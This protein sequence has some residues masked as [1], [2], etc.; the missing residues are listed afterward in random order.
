VQCTTNNFSLE[1]LSVS[2]YIKQIKTNRYSRGGVS[3]SA[4]YRKYTQCV[5]NGA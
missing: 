4:F 3:Q 5:E 1:L 2:Y